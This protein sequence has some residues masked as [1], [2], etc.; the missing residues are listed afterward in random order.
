MQSSVVL[1]VMG[2]QTK[3]YHDLSLDLDLSDRLA[4][5]DG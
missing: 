4:E 3:P 5:P 2:K 1:R